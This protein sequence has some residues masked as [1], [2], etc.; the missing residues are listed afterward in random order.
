MAI[1]SMKSRQMR[2]DRKDRLCNLK[3]GCL[4]YCLTAATGSREGD[5]KAAKANN[6]FP[7]SP[8]LGE[9]YKK[10]FASILTPRMGV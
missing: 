2:P 1:R 3:A 4:D 9:Y 5:E 8:K 10:D 6:S 7:A